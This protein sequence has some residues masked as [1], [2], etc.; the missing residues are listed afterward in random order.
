MTMPMTT[1]PMRDDGGVRILYAT[2]GSAGAAVAL[3]FLS[4]LSLSAADAVLVVSHPA[5]FLVARPGEGIVGRAI[6]RQR[7]HAAEIVDHA[8]ALLRSRGI[9]AGGFVQDG[10]DAVDA[11]LRA[12]ESGRAELVVVGSRGLGPLSSLLVG[13]TARTLAMLSPVP[14]LVVR[15]RRSAPLRVLVAVDGS[16]ASSAAVGFLRKLPMPADAT[17]E[18]LHVLP[19]REWSVLG[20]M[21]G[22]LADLRD[23]AERDDERDA[24][25]LIRE[26]ST[27][28]SGATV[29]P[30]LVHGPVAET[31]IT[32]ASAIDADLVVLGSRG[33]SGPRRP[34]WGSTAERVLVSVRCPV[35][36]AP[37][38]IGAAVDAGQKSDISDQVLV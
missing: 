21:N 8:I 29:R 23:A 16:P 33:M 19:T 13:S 37:M 18:L 31:I 14:V 3:D 11:I 9:S 26:A 6:E 32:R 15:D 17:V 4:S 24:E 7:R 25:R 35:L 12:S 10:E 22:E 20:P 38:P 2:D 1:D 30:H 34:F 28:L 27:L 36:I 5:F